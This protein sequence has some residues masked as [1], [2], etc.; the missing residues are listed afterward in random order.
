MKQHL[1]TVFILAFYSP[2][3]SQKYSACATETFVKLGLKGLYLFI[4]DH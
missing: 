1:K 3:N 2:S 4:L